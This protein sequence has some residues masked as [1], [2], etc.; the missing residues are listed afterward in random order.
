DVYSIGIVVFEMLT[1]RLPYIGANQ[2]ELALA[3]IRERI[4]SVTEFNPAVPESLAKIIQKVMSKDPN[5]RYSN[6][7]QLG[8]VLK[9][10]RDRARQGT[11]TDTPIEATDS[12]PL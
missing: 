12:R 4:P 8:N 3:H 6:A 9:S 5:A 10:Y 2:Q 11:L 1:G 7:D